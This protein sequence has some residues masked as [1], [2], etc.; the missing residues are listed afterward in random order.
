MEIT[1]DNINVSSD[2]PA[3]SR[4]TPAGGRAVT[5]RWLSM[6][7]L[8]ADHPWVTVR[9]PDGERRMSVRPPVCFFRQLHPKFPR[10]TER[11]P[12]GNWAAP[13]RTP[14]DELICVT[15][16]DHPAKFN[17]ELKCS[18]HHRMSKGW[19]LQVCL[20]GRRVPNFCRIWC[21]S[22]RAAIWRSIF[23]YWDGSFTSSKYPPS[24]SRSWSHMWL[25]WSLYVYMESNCCLAMQTGEVSQQPKHSKFLMN[26][27]NYIL[28]Q[29]QH[30]TGNRELTLAWSFWLPHDNQTLLTFHGDFTQTCSLFWDRP[31]GCGFN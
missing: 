17:C 30:Y 15:S 4:Q 2:D 28:Y 3:V 8:P 1:A 27:S 21:K 9:R 7:R 16:A 19:A 11:R 31:W 6:S 20:F 13:R 24:F 25:M 22:C 23:L 14:A 18:G 5:V 12:A 10:V 29:G 26:I